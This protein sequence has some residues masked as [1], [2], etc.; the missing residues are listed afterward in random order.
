MRVLPLW[1]LFSGKSGAFEGPGFH[2]YSPME[3]IPEM[4]VLLV[5]MDFFCFPQMDAF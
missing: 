3:P 1:R 5:K 2:G 4:V